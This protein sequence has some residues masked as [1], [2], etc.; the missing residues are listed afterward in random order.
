MTAPTCEH[1]KGRLLTPKE[2]AAQLRKHISYIYAM[3]RAG[4][5]MPGGVARLEAALAWLI[6]N[7]P[8]RSRKTS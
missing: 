7:R 8:P 6:R 4:F 3:K 5:Q 1:C 2:L